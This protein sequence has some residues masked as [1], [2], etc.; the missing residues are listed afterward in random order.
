MNIYYR[1][2][3]D[4]IITLQKNPEVNWRGYSLTIMTTLT[5]LNF[6]AVVIF[7]AFIGINI[8]L[9]SL[10]IFSGSLLGK[11][12]DM[13]ITFGLPAFLI[14]YYL[15]FYKS[16][17]KVIINDYPDK[18]GKLFILYTMIS[19]GLFFLPVFVYWLVY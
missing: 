2:W 14:H 13:V 9:I 10:D 17:Y 12:L 15:V 19:L 6:V 1:I 7:L 11:F 8:N 5:A 18:K 3:A 16:R 4:T